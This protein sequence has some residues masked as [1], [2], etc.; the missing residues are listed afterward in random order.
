MGNGFVSVGEDAFFS[1]VRAWSLVGV[2]VGAAWAAANLTFRPAELNFEEGWYCEM[3]ALK[4]EALRLVLARTAR[5][6]IY[7]IMMAVRIIQ[8]R[9]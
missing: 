1:F 5:R 6:S 9:S 4:V 8:I 2:D 7:R 3:G